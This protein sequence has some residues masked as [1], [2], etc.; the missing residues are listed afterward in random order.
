MADLTITA[1]NVI[2]DSRARISEG[3]AGA[4]ITAGKVIY[5]DPVSDT[6]KLA[7][8]NSSTAAARSPVGIALHGAF[9]GQ[10][11]QFAESGP[12]TMGAALTP[13]V[14][15]YLSDTPGG[16][17]PV[18]DVGDAEYAVILGIAISNSVLKFKVLES[19]VAIGVPVSGAVAG[20][21]SAVGAGGAGGGG[22]SGSGVAA[23]VM[24]AAGV[25]GAGGVAAGGL[26]TFPATVNASL[27][28]VQL[29]LL[30]ANNVY[31]AQFGLLDTVNIVSGDVLWIVVTD[32]ETD[33]TPDYLYLAITDALINQ[34]EPR[35]WTVPGLNNYT[36]GTHRFT[37][38]VARGS[39]RGLPGAKVT[40][41]PDD[42]RPL[43][44]YPQAVESIGSSNA[45]WG[46]TPS[47]D[48]TIKTVLT[49]NNVMPS[50]AQI[51]AGQNSSG[52]AAIAQSPVVA[53]AH[54]PTDI[55]LNG[56]TAGQTAYIWAY[57]EDGQGNKSDV[58]SGG[59]V[60]FVAPALSTDTLLNAA[61][62]GAYSQ[63]VDGG[64]TLTHTSAGASEI[65]YA[66]SGSRSTTSKTGDRYAEFTIGGAGDGGA[67]IGV[68]NAAY[69]VAATG[70][71]PGY[72]NNDCFA[73]VSDGGFGYGGTDGG[74]AGG[75]GFGFGPG[76][77]V[78]I[79]LQTDYQ[80]VVG[81]TAVT[82]FLNGVLKI[83]LW[84]D[85]GELAAPYLLVKSQKLFIVTMNTG[86][87]AFAYAP[88]VGAQPWDA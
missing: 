15:Y 69:T 76:D 45:L 87:S 30:T 66:M 42:I 71:V 27:P 58:I 23:G 32:S 2:A 1:A 64:R 8:S 46:V 80:G 61:T 70:G 24:T 34:P 37:P 49:L 55:P 41:G 85:N 78:G 72:D 79:R 86:H 4:T 44:I 60:T 83:K 57:G 18:G 59:S 84:M 51:A 47:E 10:P 38:Y 29:D 35:N 9:A 22:S 5:I 48:V 25:G 52:A 67:A 39:E 20:V 3:V 88:P 53:L 33:V 56:G 65:T 13:G 6:L 75:A 17:C 68:C 16:I 28:V 62:L 81:R 19:G 63:L 77:K 40:H 31:P 50:T 7:D 11:L 14:V 43:L 36:S 21:L 73:A 54:T 74:D 82:W 26:P 12:V